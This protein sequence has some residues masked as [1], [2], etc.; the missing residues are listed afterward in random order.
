MCLKE[1]IR[2]AI[3]LGVRKAASICTMDQIK[4]ERHVQ[5]THIRELVSPPNGNGFDNNLEIDGSTTPTLYDYI[6]KFTCIHN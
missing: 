1:R 3:L 6:G 2:C 4:L 5:P